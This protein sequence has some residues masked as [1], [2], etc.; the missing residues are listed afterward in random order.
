MQLDHRIRVNYN[1]HVGMDVGENYG[2]RNEG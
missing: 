2:T 1:F